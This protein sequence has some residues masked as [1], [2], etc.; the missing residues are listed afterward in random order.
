MT[1]QSWDKA[2][3]SSLGVAAFNAAF[4]ACCLLIAAWFSGVV[5]VLMETAKRKGD[6]KK[7]ILFIGVCLLVICGGYTALHYYFLQED[8]FDYQ[9]ALIL[10]GKST[11]LAALWVLLFHQVSQFQMSF[12]HWKHF[13][14]YG[15]C[16][17]IVLLFWYT[18]FILALMRQGLSADTFFLHDWLKFLVLAELPIAAYAAVRTFAIFIHHEFDQLVSRNAKENIVPGVVAV[19]LC[20]F[21]SYLASYI[22]KDAYEPD[23]CSYTCGYKLEIAAALMAWAICLVV[24]FYEKLAKIPVVHP[25]RELMGIGLVVLMCA[26]VAYVHEFS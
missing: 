2:S 9:A 20:V 11:A 25:V 26:V 19:G 18:A 21:I 6:M 1:K 10:W 23:G 15:E 22:S 13:D 3:E 17:G 8:H 12:D 5:Y 14:H 16:A 24:T 7:V 4:A